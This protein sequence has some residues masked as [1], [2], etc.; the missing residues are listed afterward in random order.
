MVDESCNPRLDNGGFL[1]S[2]LVKDVYYDAF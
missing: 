1:L 2:K